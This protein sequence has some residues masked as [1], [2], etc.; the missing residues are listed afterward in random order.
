[1]SQQL[2]STKHRLHRHVRPERNSRPSWR[3]GSLDSWRDDRGSSQALSPD[4][5]WPLVQGPA[6]GKKFLNSCGSK[7][8]KSIPL[9]RS[10]YCPGQGPKRG[11]LTALEWRMFPPLK[12]LKMVELELL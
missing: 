2:Q 1:M 12:G 5:W 4:G 11:E 3:R 9:R 7:G 10:I 6:P 8:S